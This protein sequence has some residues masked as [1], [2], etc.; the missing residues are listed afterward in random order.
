MTLVSN[1][2]SACCIHHL[3]VSCGIGVLLGVCSDITRCSSVEG[4]LHQMFLLELSIAKYMVKGAWRLHPL[5]FNRL[6]QEY[7]VA[8]LDCILPT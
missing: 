8:R 7:I 4:L 6:L 5:L 3:H 2:Q 1:C